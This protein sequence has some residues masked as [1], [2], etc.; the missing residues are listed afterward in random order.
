MFLLLRYFTRKS[1]K[2]PR[3][4]CLNLEIHVR[5]FEP[6]TQTKSNTLYFWNFQH[7]CGADDEFSVRLPTNSFCMFTVYLFISHSF[8]RQ[9]S[10]TNNIISLIKRSQKEVN[11]QY[12]DQ[13]ET[14]ETHTHTHKTHLKEQV[15]L[16]R[17][18]HFHCFHLFILSPDNPK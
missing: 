1:K 13:E 12:R 7:A 16:K 8:I 6:C 15:V 9:E 14:R 11:T 3:Q 2:K 17:L 4:I 5:C 18:S 10:I